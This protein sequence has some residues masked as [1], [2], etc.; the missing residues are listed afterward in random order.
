M[1]MIQG[2]FNCWCMR[3]HSH[4]IGD[5]LKDDERRSQYLITSRF[6]LVNNSSIDYAGQM[7]H[8]SQYIQNYL[9]ATYISLAKLDFDLSLTP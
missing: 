9:H 7:A 8:L 4:R 5:I 1:C 3:K 2:E 6:L